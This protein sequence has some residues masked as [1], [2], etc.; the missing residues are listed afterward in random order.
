MA[1]IRTT[2]IILA[3]LSM[4]V[5]GSACAQAGPVGDRHEVTEAQP[6]QSR[7]LAQAEKKDNQSKQLL[8]QGHQKIL[9]KVEAVTSDQ[10]K[11]DIGEVHP[12]FLPLKQAQEKNFPPI[13]PGDDLIIT[14][15]D[16]NL[17]VDYHPL[18]SPSPN[19]KVVRGKI[20]D[21]M[22]IGHDRVVIKGADGKEQSF[23]VRSQARSKLA[24]IPV[25][26][27]AIF[28][29]DETN[30]VTDATFASV[31][32]AKEAHKNFDDKSSIKGAH[33]QID[34]TVVEPLRVDRITLKTK[35]GERPFEVRDVMHERISQLRKGESVIL[36][37]DNENKVVDIA[38]PPQSSR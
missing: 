35:D 31:G 27:P 2:S 25:G 16:Q 18:E 4:V 11:V 34:G 13:N 12:R 28:L 14:V 33:R 37:V 26:T 15:N 29:I 19:H 22:P 9:G 36:L 6:A 5:L 30:Q 8:L 17:I 1:E 3:G 20:A 10:I 24:S 7:L 38:V 32:A 21:T 23:D